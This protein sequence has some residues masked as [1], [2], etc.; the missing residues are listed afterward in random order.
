MTYIY[1]PLLALLITL[2][3]LLT[4]L[5][6]LFVIPFIRWDKH[7]TT[8]PQRSLAPVPTIMGDLPWWLSWFQTPDQ[9]FPGDLAIPEV[10]DLFNR[11][12]KWVTAYVWCGLRNR[13]MGLAVWLGGRTSDYAPE[14]VPGLWKRTDQYGHVWKY[15]LSF[16]KLH[17]I[18]GHN[19]YKMLDDSFRYAPVLT[20]KYR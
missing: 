12:G 20:V 14:D 19:V 10:G 9:R 16:G 15:T 6:A 5:L 18:T 7:I 3:S 17:I 11:R 13:I 8:Q 4:P 1:T 2:V